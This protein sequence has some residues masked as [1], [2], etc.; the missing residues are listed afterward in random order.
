[1]MDKTRAVP[2]P[3][4]RVRRLAR[5]VIGPSPLRRSC[6]R[7]EGLV[8]VLLLALFLAAA[9]AAPGLGE[10]LYQSQR[11]DAAHLRPATAVLTDSGPPGTFMTTGWQ[12]TARWLA[13]DGQP[14]SGTLTPVTAPGITGAPAGARVRVWLTGSGQPQD[15]PVSAAGRAF[16]SVVIPVGGVCGTA[17]AL[18]ICYWLCRRALDRRRLAAWTREWSRTGPRWTAH[19]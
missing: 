6:D 10:R 17:I 4:G 5:M 19:R 1:M 3:A 16:A 15:P 12:A 13:P 11:A 14:R 7:V 18:I 2:R 9:A 8:V